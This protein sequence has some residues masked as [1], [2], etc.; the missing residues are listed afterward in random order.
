MARKPYQ[1]QLSSLVWLVIGSAFLFGVIRYV[2][3]S[4]LQR[5]ATEASTNVSRDIRL[6]GLRPRDWDV[7]LIVTPCILAP[8]VW[9]F[10]RR[11][12]IKQKAGNNDSISHSPAAPI[13]QRLSQ[14][15]SNVAPVEPAPVPEE[16]QVL[17][18]IATDGPPPRPPDKLSRLL[19][20]IQGS[21]RPDSH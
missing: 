5:A 6:L 2:S 3:S 18:P 21:S 16:Q 11:N 9:L 20:R 7:I 12:P 17:P 4:A 14:F 10:T 8:L 13:E 19:H 1:F 15:M